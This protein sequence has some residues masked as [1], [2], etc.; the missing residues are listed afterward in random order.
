VLSRGLASINDDLRSRTKYSMETQLASFNGTE[1]ES[2]GAVSVPIYQTANFD[3]REQDKFDYTRSGN[4]TRHALEELCR[5]LENADGAFAF[6]SDMAAVSAITR[7]LRPGDYVL[8]SKDISGDTHRLLLN[9]VEYSGIQVEF[10]ETCNTE[11]VRNAFAE[12]EAKGGVVSMLFVE[13]PSNPQLKVSDIRALARLTR[14]QNAYFCVD[15]SLMSP[16]CMNPLELGADV[17]IHSASKFIAG[18]SDV[19]AG[20]IMCKGVEICK[21]IAFVQNTEGSGLAPF[22]SWLVLRGAKTMALRVAAGQVNAV[23]VDR[24]LCNHPY[25][26]KVYYLTLPNDRG[27]HDKDTDTRRSAGNLD[28]KDQARLHFSQAKG[29]GAVLS[30]EMGSAELAQAVVANTQ[31]FKHTVSYGSCSSF[32]EIPAGPRGSHECAMYGGTGGIGNTTSPLSPALIRLSL[33]IEASA[34]LINDVSK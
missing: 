27:L 11:G 24:F 2:T 4:P 12:R 10:I 3:C 32:I 16:F 14:S 7:L 25:V 26:K 9:A 17:C 33:G 18:H 23:E 22:D 29:G 34:D 20:V 5:R 28:W 8:A 21:H 19:M 6:T 31:L 30:F 1:A 13:S 15:N